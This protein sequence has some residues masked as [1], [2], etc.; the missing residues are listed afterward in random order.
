M[1]C[2]Q[3]AGVYCKI[4]SGAKMAPW[5]SGQ[6]AALSRLNPGFD[7]P[8]GHQIAKARQIWRAFAIW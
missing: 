6:D 1:N 8:W 4:A 3:R 7:S 5:S 2:L